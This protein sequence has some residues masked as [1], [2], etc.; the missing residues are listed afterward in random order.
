MLCSQPIPAGT[1]YIY[2]RL[3]PHV[4][5]DHDYWWTYR[6]H[7]ECDRILTEVL[8]ELGGECEVPLSPSKWQEILELHAD[9][10]RI[11]AERAER[12]RRY[13]ELQEKLRQERLRRQM[14]YSSGGDSD[15]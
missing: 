9:L 1:Q 13:R 15:A 7:P 6:A 2:E 10:P 4:S 5:S 12:E 8:P 11:R 14:A 3:G